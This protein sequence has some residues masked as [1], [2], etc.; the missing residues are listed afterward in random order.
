MSGD[1]TIRG[2]QEAQAANV[3]IIAALRPSGAFGR[4]IQYATASAHRYAASVT[5]VDTGAWRAS[6]R[7]AVTGLRGDVFLAAGALNPRSGTPVETYATIWEARGGRHAAYRRTVDEA[8][9]RIQAE[10][11]AMVLGDLPT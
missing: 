5:A 4:A 1:V 7:M 10:A 8:G 11:G 9:P 6:H 2:L 3:Q